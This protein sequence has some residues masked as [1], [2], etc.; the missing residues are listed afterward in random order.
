MS[1]RSLIPPYAAAELLEPLNLLPP[2][3]ILTPREDQPI[4]VHVDG[5]RHQQNKHLLLPIPEPLIR[6][7]LND[8]DIYHARGVKLGPSELVEAY[9]Q[10]LPRRTQAICVLKTYAPVEILE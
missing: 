2:G 4:I 9:D 10:P 5:V 1:L 8:D 7:I 3:T 6:I